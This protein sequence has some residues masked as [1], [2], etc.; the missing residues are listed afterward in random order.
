[1]YKQLVMTD[2]N[3]ELDQREAFLAGLRGDIDHALRVLDLHKI[4]DMR[5]ADLEAHFGLIVSETWEEPNLP[6]SD[7]EPYEEA[8]HAA[9]VDF[10]KY[11]ESLKTDAETEF[12]LK[13]KIEQ[14]DFKAYLH[15]VLR[16]SL[17]N[18]LVDT[19]ENTG[20]LYNVKTPDP[21]KLVKHFN[22]VAS[23]LKKRLKEDYD[24]SATLSEADIAK[25][26]ALYA[27]TFANKS[28]FSEAQK[29]IVSHVVETEATAA[30]T[31]LN[32]P[33]LKHPDQVLEIGRDVRD[34]TLA[35]LF[36][37]AERTHMIPNDIR[38]LDTKTLGFKAPVRTL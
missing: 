19:A 31:K 13:E 18:R 12:R 33:R 7:I 15:T 32:D 5:L 34:K 21:I 23:E 36:D 14:P 1:M 17:E 11:Y 37:I 4:H 8:T 9:L 26:A 24:P 2:D 28:A 10:K 6:V 16:T 3:I 20:L 22:K 35:S 30:L 27:R 38:D 29:I 25:T